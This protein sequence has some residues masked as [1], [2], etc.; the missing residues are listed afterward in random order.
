MLSANVDAHITF[1][2][3]LL[4]FQVRLANNP[5][6]LDKHS[7]FEYETHFTVMVCLSITFMHNDCF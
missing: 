4:Y 3:S 2:F 6:S 5:Y 7:F 1:C